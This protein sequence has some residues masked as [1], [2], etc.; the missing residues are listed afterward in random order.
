[1]EKGERLDRLARRARLP[2][3]LDGKSRDRE[4]ENAG[5]LALAVSRRHKQGRHPSETETR[6]RSAELLPSVIN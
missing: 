3:I 1:M 6:A 2:F 5:V 4:L